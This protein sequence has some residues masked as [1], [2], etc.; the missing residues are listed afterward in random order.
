MNIAQ[1]FREPG[2][3]YS[4]Q[5]PEE[6]FLQGAERNYRQ[7]MDLYGQ[8]PGGGF[9]GDENCRPGF[10]DPHQGFETCGMVEFMHSFEMLTKISG[11]PVWSDR[12]GGYRLQLVAGG[13]HARL[14]RPALPDLRQP[15]AARRNN[16]APGIQ[17]GGTMF[18]YS[19]VEVYRCC[20]HNVSHG[21]PYY[22]EELWLATA[23]RGLCASL[24]AAS[25]VTAKVGG[26]GDAN[27]ATT[28]KVIEETDYPFG[29]VVSLRLSMAKPTTFPLYLR[30]PQWCEK[31]T[32]E[33]NGKP[34]EA[35][36]KPSSYMII[37]R[38]WNEGD[39]VK[40]HLP[41][42]LAVK[43]WKQNHDAVSVSK[44]PLSFSLKIGE[45]W[46]RS[47]GSDAW[48]EYEVFPATAWNCGLV[49]DEQNPAKSFEVA[50]K[51]FS[52]NA[53][54]FTTE[55]RRSSSRQPPKKSTPGNSTP[56]AWPRSC[57]TAQ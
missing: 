35:A 27:D 11:N 50:Y 36:A 32:V 55:G 1:G 5:A 2:V 25:E 13:D 51:P 9:A 18:S 34:L 37:T 12:C 6:K 57:R 10:T 31:A 53:N 23:D 20:Q 40:L 29:D 3:F 47:G 54:P 22:A 38:R 24:Y 21:W 45:K 19:P 26:S 28:V 7:V 17:N 46:S 42:P 52:P 4:Q 56:T 33:L 30:I 16:H 43:K 39:T 14:E 44:G 48:P 49:L 41:M 8:F 15:G